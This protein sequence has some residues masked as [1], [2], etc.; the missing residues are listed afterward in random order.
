MTVI[1]SS[2]LL[3]SFLEVM[4]TI[5]YST[6]SFKYSCLF[7]ARCISRVS[8]ATNESLQRPFSEVPTPKGAIPLLGHRLVMKK[9]MMN[10]TR[11][12]CLQEWFEEL[13]PI[14]KLHFTGGNV[15]SMR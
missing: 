12:Q 5:T 3:V 6:S 1:R 7:F 15:I 8:T 2:P 4:A 14:F 11:S 9:G 13:G 10:K